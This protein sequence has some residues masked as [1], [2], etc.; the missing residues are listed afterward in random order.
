MNEIRVGKVSS[1]NYPA[2]M[3]KVTYTDKDNS[4]TQEIPLLN[5]EYKMPP[6]G[7]QVLVINL[8]N[9]GE[10]GFVL[11][12]PW[13]EVTKPVEGFEGLY[14]KEL[15]NNNGEAYVRYV[16]GQEFQLK[17]PKATIS[18]DNQGNIEIKTKNAV[19][20][21]SDASVTIKTPKGITSF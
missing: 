12:R 14:R 18:I 19:S 11:G 21:E 17:L 13:S 7:A 5:V 16:T 15:S 4:T 8:S 3:V 20:I 9:G 10:V 6:V 2:G 1:I